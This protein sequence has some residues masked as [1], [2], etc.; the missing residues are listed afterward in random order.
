MPTVFYLLLLLLF[1]LF[2]RLACRRVCVHSSAGWQIGDRRLCGALNSAAFC[3]HKKS[4]LGMRGGGENMLATLLL[5]AFAHFISI[6]MR[7]L[8]FGFVTVLRAV[9]AV[10]VAEMSVRPGPQ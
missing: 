4:H 1:C 7:C 2:R 8:F 10:V 6:A 5:A 3:S 9:L